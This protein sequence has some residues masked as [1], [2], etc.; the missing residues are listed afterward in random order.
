MMGFFNQNERPDNLNN[1]DAVATYFTDLIPHPVT[2]ALIF[3]CKLKGDFDGELA[4]LNS[5]LRHDHLEGYALV[6][7]VKRLISLAFVTL[8]SC[9]YELKKRV[10]GL[11]DG[12]KAEFRKARY[13]RIFESVLQKEEITYDL[14]VFSLIEVWVALKKGALGA[15]VFGAFF[16]NMDNDFGVVL[17]K[18]LGVIKNAS[19]KET[20]GQ[21]SE[22]DVKLLLCQLIEGFVFLRTLAVDYRDDFTLSCLINFRLNQFRPNDIFPAV[23][24]ILTQ[25]ELLR[26]RAEQQGEPIAESTG[27]KKA[28]KILPYL[29]VASSEFKSK[30]QC[31]YRAFDDTVEIKIDVEV[32]ETDKETLVLSDFDLKELRKVLS[33]DFKNLR[34]FA[35][36]ISDSLNQANK[37]LLFD[38]CK[39]R[40]PTILPK[41]T[42]SESE[43]IYWDNVVT[44][45]LVEMGPSDFLYA[46][47]NDDLYAQLLKNMSY[48]CI[49]QTAKAQM[50][51]HF[52][53]E[54]ERL[55]TVCGDKKQ[56]MF[57]H[58][59]KLLQCNTI[60]QM[61]ELKTEDDKTAFSP[62]EESL[63]YKFDSLQTSLRALGRVDISLEE[64]N[65]HKETLVECF[66][67][68]FLLLQIFYAGLN[69]YSKEIQHGGS[70]RS[71]EQ[72]Y[73][74]GKNSFIAGAKKKYQEIKDYAL[75]Q[76]YQS[77]F[78]M[79][80]EYNTTASSDGF[81]VSEKAKNLK[82]VLTRN[83]I[84]DVEKLEYFASITLDDGTQTNLFAMLENINEY[85]KQKNYRKW[86]GYFRDFF[87]FLIYNDDYTERGIYENEPERLV[88]KDYDPVYPYVVFY[89]Q[90]NIDKDH[91]KKCNY[92]VPIPCN[93]L[94][95]ENK[96]EGF[97]V[98]LLTDNEYTPNGNYFC[99][100]LKYG[101]TEDW[102]I[103]PFM[104]STQEFAKIMD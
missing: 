53:A 87:M 82:Y 30:K 103:N 28:M 90:E 67:N 12:E 39:G 83:Y 35:L 77:F 54:V 61:T 41:I 6:S 102:W 81:N 57:A 69:E 17:Q 26:L 91:L 66:R 22:L 71:K 68:I 24:F 47:M 34:S 38:L 48:R 98:T 95:E 14:E 23:K 7:S 52:K 45:L 15:G 36:V 79:C 16:S 59:K 55:K 100:P 78:D 75:A 93:R 11:S 56:A 27:K 10:N 9:W 4:Q 72:I 86:L 104:I 70:L 42:D 84:C 62:F 58:H 63:M 32:E 64:C 85:T 37:K 2:R 97:M 74:D 18:A 88:D 1:N 44:L 40:Y 29:M 73:A 46:I 25:S 20:A 92:R 50:E 96:N 76:T 21:Y 101:S 89:Y 3:E 65:L 33:F 13:S 80:A 60:I 43:A 49:D 19:F 99:I 5:E 94:T 31:L 8:F 51:L